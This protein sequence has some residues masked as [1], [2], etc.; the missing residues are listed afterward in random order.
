MNISIWRA[1]LWNTN[2]RKTHLPS[3]HSLHKYLYEHFLFSSCDA[4]LHNY[5]L[6]LMN[7]WCLDISVHLYFTHVWRN[8]LSMV[9]AARYMW[10]WMQRGIKLTNIGYII[11]L[12]SKY[13]YCRHGFYG[14]FTERRKMTTKAAKRTVPHI[15]DMIP[16]IKYNVAGDC[17]G[18]C[19]W[20]PIPP[21][22]VNHHINSPIIQDTLIYNQFD[23]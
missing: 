10:I 8:I 5:M 2:Q 1:L 15:T 23:I 22:T 4:Y 16:D 18:Y 3:S 17:N 14:V 6:N 20:H 21:N 11:R 9:N 7:P 13:K 12:L 19:G